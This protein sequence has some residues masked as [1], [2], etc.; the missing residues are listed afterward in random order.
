MTF[1]SAGRVAGSGPASCS[2]TIQSPGAV[3]AFPGAPIGL[4]YRIPPGVR[5]LRLPF[6]YLPLCQRSLRFAF[7]DQFWTTPAVPASSISFLPDYPRVS[8]VG[9]AVPRESRDDIGLR[10]CNS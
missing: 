7:H 3:P 9:Y 8:L 5:R 2:T 1:S 6:A 10:S 4:N